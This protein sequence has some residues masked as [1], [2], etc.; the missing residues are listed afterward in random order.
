MREYGLEHYSRFSIISDAEI[1][2]FVKDFMSKHG[3]ATGE[4]YI[5]GHLRALV[6]RDYWMVGECVRFLCTSCERLLNER[7]SAAN[8]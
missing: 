1:D 3:H 5:S 6:Y 8:E 4:I 7:V 2:I